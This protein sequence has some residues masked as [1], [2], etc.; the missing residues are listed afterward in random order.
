MSAI[1]D[2]ILMKLAPGLQPAVVADLTPLL[3]RT[4]LGLLMAETA[5]LLATPS[6]SSK[7]NTAI[8]SREESS[9]CLEV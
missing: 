7:V 6:A 5:V 4:D 2:F 3:H 8:D 9:V 1:N